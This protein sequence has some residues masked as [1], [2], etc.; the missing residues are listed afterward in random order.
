[1]ADP[2]ATMELAERIS[3][4][5]ALPMLGAVVAS[6]ALDTGYP[7]ATIGALCLVSTLVALARH[8][9]PRSFMPTLVTLGRGLLTCVLIGEGAAFSG[10]TIAVCITVVFGLDGLDG[11]LARRMDSVSV[12][13][14]RLDMETDALL[15]MGSCFLLVLHSELGL[16]AL[17]GGVLRYAYVLVIWALGAH[18]EAPRSPFARYAFAVSLSSLA[19]GFVIPGPARAFG[20]AVATTVLVVSFGRSFYWSLRGDSARRSQSK[21]TSEPS[22]K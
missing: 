5:T 10:E 14:E 21:S 15:V 8:R 11:L 19:L 4:T 6:C 16:W 13:G 1:M 20:P 2:H 18:G 9:R 3:R 17:T 7:L 22:S 12:L